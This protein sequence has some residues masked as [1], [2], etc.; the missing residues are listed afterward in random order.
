MKLVYFIVVI[1]III[2]YNDF[3]I[4]YVIQ[5]IVMS[6]EKVLLSFVK[7]KE[8]SMLDIDDVILEWMFLLMSYNVLVDCY[9]QLMMYFYRDFVYLY[10][11]ICYK[12]L[13]EEFWYFNCDVICLQEVGF[14][15]Y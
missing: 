4:Y 7:R 3:L 2:E 11:D 14:R 12:S 10:I 9:I 5:E 13:L 8:V 15:Y 6:K 1:C